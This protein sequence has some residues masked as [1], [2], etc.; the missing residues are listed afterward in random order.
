MKKFLT[1]LTMVALFVVLVVGGTVGFL[2]SR[3]T[4]ASLPA[5][6]ASFA[7]QTLTVNGYSWGVPVLGGVVWR[8]FQQSVTADVQDL[9]TIDQVTPA[10]VLAEG[11][12]PEG[13]FLVL[14]AA[15]GCPVLEC[16]D[17][18]A[19]LDALLAE[20]EAYRVAEL[21]RT[22]VAAPALRPAAAWG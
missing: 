2:Y 16:A 13:S 4:A 9:G 20:L 19:V 21:S 11:L 6:G 5:E 12:D 10:V 14:T 1:W 17:T 22:V 18:P 15:D 8:T 3:T 7:G